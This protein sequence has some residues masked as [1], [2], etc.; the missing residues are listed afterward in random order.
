[1]FKKGQPF[2][3]ILLMLQLV[4]GATAWMHSGHLC[5]MDDGCSEA[6]Q[7]TCCM[8]DEAIP[9]EHSPFLNEI[10][11]ANNAEENCCFEINTYFNIP[12]YRIFKTELPSDHSTIAFLGNLS[13]DVAG[14]YPSQKDNFC[15]QIFAE[16]ASPPA[17]KLLLY[18]VFRI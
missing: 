8:E 17:E 11:N 10:L 12:L 7:A 18:S 5:K 15:Q 2:L 1:M 9:L 14:F 16:S 13:V 4:L 3:L 6:S